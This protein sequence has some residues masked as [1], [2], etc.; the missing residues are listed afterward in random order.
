MKRINESVESYKALRENRARLIA[1]E[2]KKSEAEK[3]VKENFMNDYYIKRDMRDRMERN[4]ARLMEGARDDA[5]ATIVKAIYITALEAETL[6]DEGLLLAESM[7]DTWIKESGGASKILGKCGNNSYLLSRIT[8]LVEDAAEE[9]VAD[10]EKDVDKEEEETAAA[11]VQQ[12]KDTALDVAKQFIDGADKKELKDFVDQIKKSADDRKDDIKDEDK[13]EKAEKEAEKAQDKADKAEEKAE[14]AKEKVEKNEAEKDTS[15]AAKELSTDDSENTEDTD[16]DGTPDSV[17]SDAD[18]NGEEDGESTEETPEAED[19]TEEKS[20]DKEEES[21]E[22]TEEPKEEKSEEDP[23]GGDL[24]DEDD[25]DE[26]DDKSEDSGDKAEDSKVPEEDGAEASSDEGESKEEEVPEGSTEGDGENN[27]SDEESEDSENIEDKSDDEDNDDEDDEDITI[28]GESDEDTESS[29]K[30]FD[31]LDKEEDV[32]K[33]IEI[34][35]SRI[36]DAE[37]TFI[38]NNAEDKKK[39]DELLNKI[40]TN[41]KTVEDLNDKDSAESKIAEE[42]VRMD[43]RRIEAIRDNR[44]LT[45]FEAMTRNFSK[46]LIKDD[47]AK[48]DYLNE[49]GALDTG[50]IVES[51][52][53]MYGFLETINTLHLEKV[54]EEYIKNVLDNM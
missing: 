37:E 43:K 23:L 42:S 47:R 5:L 36:A 18:G 35:R 51:A 26:D 29:G 2:I 53:V 22:K 24:E 52:K 1:E 46:S 14:K 21:A 8:Q 17:D 12:D 19:N 34:I 20:D 11:E 10:I 48:E 9:E 16:S 40:A 32:H 13:A 44:T 45:V 39:V 50:L 38:K 41:V 31:E 33:A 28:D 25:D 49:S 54:D 7:V 27:K 6:T 15:D 4:H 30:V 3:A